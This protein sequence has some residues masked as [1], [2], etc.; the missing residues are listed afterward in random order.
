MDTGSGSQPDVAA[1]P[2]AG[3]ASMSSS[4]RPHDGRADAVG[5]CRLAIIGCVRRDG[6]LTLQYSLWPVPEAL[7]GD[8]RLHE[9]EDAG[10]AVGSR[11]MGR[12]TADP[13]S[14]SAYRVASDGKRVVGAIRFGPAT[15][16]TL[17]VLR[18]LFAPLAHTPGLDEWLCEVRVTLDANAVRT[19][20]VRQA[21]DRPRW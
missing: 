7:L 6:F 2:A 16:P 15:W 9:G 18:V 17:G 19:T 5:R 10:I 4:V 20:T 11:G 21:D 13:R 12:R 14:R 1:R 8:Q 3:R